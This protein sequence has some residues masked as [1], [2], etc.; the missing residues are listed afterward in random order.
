MKDSIRDHATEIA[1][2]VG[3]L[4]ESRSIL[5]VTGA[6]ISADSGLPPY[7][8]IG[9][10]YNPNATE[11]GMPIEQALSGDVMEQ[12]P[13]LT[14]KYLAQVERACRGARHNRAHEVIAEMEA[15]FT[16]VWTLTQNVDGFHRAAGARNV[17]DI[18]GDTARPT[19]CM[20]LRAREGQFAAASSCASISSASHG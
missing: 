6:G 16:R 17:I 13:E 5:F 15:R 4:A 19:L 8:G 12:R 1:R 9:G 10:L 11:E 20:H 14:W 18:H 3:M 7:R 2:V